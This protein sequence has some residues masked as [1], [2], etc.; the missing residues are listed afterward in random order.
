MSAPEQ[1]TSGANPENDPAVEFEST[2][3]WPIDDPEQTAHIQRPPTTPPTPASPTPAS[4][5]PAEPSAPASVA[6]PPTATPPPASAPT[7]ADPAPHVDP[8]ATSVVPRP[9]G[10]Y[11]QPWAATTP[12][13]A[14]TPPAPTPGFSGYPPPHESAG[15]YHQQYGGYPQGAGY[16]PA[17]GY[18]PGPSGYPGGYQPN[19]GYPQPQQSAAAESA[20]GSFEFTPTTAI[21]SGRRR[22]T[23]LLIG[24]G[25]AVIAIAAVGVTGFW[26]PGFLVKRQLNIAKVQEGVQHILTDP[27]AGYGISGVSGV[28]CNQG[29]NPSANP[30]DKFTCELQISGSAGKR[31]VEVTVVDD[32]G[33]Y[34]VG[35]VT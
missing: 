32:H 13:P 8:E 33:T 26:K 24:A 10:N 20:T 3:L 2:G 27:N 30:G 7:A 23:A 21:R 16:Q 34:Q 28:A 6:T 18:P 31:H 15:G 4:P 22:R 9:T 5:A 1:G 25:V 19:P 35:K 11:T 14:P 12:A 29:Q 17:P